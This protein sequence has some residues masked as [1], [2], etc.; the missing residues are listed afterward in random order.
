[1]GIRG[2]AERVEALRHYAYSANT[3]RSMERPLLERGVPLMRVAASAAARVTAELLEHNGIDVTQ[4]HVAVLAGAGDN[5]GDG[6]FA[7]AAL[8]RARANVTVISVGK[9]LHPAGLL[10]LTRSGGKL[11]LLDPEATTATKPAGFSAGE[12]GERLRKAVDIAIECDVVIDAM[13][14]IGATG[15]LRGPAATMAHEINAR[16]KSAKPCGERVPLVIAIDTPSGVGV[17]DG[18]IP[19][20]VIAADATVMFGAMKP[21]AML[22]PAAFTC[23]EVT[24]VDFGFDLDG[25]TPAV[26]AIDQHQAAA[27]L[28]QPK[29]TDSKYSR[30]VAGLITG[31]VHYPGAAVLSVQAAIRSNIGMVRYLG[32]AVASG[33]VLDKAPEVVLGKGRVQAWAVGS[34]VPDG[35][36]PSAYEED[37]HA[38]RQREAIAA[39]L[40][41]YTTPGRLSESPSGFESPRHSETTKSEDSTFTQ[42]PWAMPPICVDAGALDLL[43]EHVP[44]QVIITPHAAELAKLLNARGQTVTVDDIN[45][46]PWRW[47]KTTH[48]L[49]GATVLL[50]GAITVIVGTDSLEGA[51]S[52]YGSA[53]A[54]ENNRTACGHTVTKISGSGPSWLATAGAGDVLAGLMSG[55]LSQQPEGAL[56]QNP[57]LSVDAAATAAFIHGIAACEACESNNHGWRPPHLYDGPETIPNDKTGHPI[58]ASDVIKQIPYVIGT[59][60]N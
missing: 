52:N 49:T 37:G 6:L 43:P 13:T 23:G 41:H 38:D 44:P 59:L 3:I 48:E 56:C 30:G 55:I 22:P 12:A 46:N 33:M 11:L 18:T 21:C 1:M 9:S 50:K 60:L 28:H 36:S 40:S 35:H 2:E 39:L 17:D 15:A 19:G 29:T 31:S 7:A 27:M 58:V 32:P 8:A 45:A 34:G 26:S 20:E 54:N 14:G 4:S 25:E 24:L 47:A 42:E 10:A 16:M 51:R 5:G 57:K 53:Q